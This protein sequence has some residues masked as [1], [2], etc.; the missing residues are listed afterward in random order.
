MRALVVLLLIL[1]GCFGARYMASGDRATPRRDGGWIIALGA[2]QIVAGAALTGAAVYTDYQPDEDSP[3]SWTDGGNR[4]K[5]IGGVLALAFVGVVLAGFGAGD[6]LAGLW[7][8]GN[9]DYVFG[10][11]PD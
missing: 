6:I 1:P 10:G 2:A 5:H 7:Q 11:Q 9:G 8:L 4:A 3:G